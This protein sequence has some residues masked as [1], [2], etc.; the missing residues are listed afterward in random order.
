MV[1]Y[2]SHLYEEYVYDLIGMDDVDDQL[3]EAQL[4]VVVK[5]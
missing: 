4:L 2:L 3:M 1:E 5:I